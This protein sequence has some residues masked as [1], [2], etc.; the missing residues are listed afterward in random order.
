MEL[1]S[2]DEKTTKY[3]ESFTGD[4]FLLPPRVVRQNCGLIPARI[5]CRSWRVR[6]LSPNINAEIMHASRTEYA[7]RSKSAQHGLGHCNKSQSGIGG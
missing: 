7:R 5:A 1:M 4:W 3:V 6:K 2:G